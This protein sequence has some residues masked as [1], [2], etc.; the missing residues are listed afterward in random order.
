VA[1]N[2]L[3]LGSQELH[4]YTTQQEEGCDVTN[5][6]FSNF[7]SAIRGKCSEVLLHYLIKE[8]L[9]KEARVDIG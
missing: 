8:N 2:A 1:R 9:A 6:F 5:L 3:I 4:I 7:N